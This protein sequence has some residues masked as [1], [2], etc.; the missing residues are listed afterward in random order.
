MKSAIDRFESFFQLDLV[1]SVA[2]G[3]K[4][5]VMDLNWIVRLFSA[6]IAKFLT[7]THTHYINS[8]HGQLHDHAIQF[9]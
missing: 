3:S 8:T 4:D 2:S 6:F 1:D 9:V 5:H 7:L